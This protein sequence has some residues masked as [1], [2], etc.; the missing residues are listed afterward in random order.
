MTSLTWI[1]VNIVQPY[2]LR[3]SW[4]GTFLAQY[5]ALLVLMVQRSRNCCSLELETFNVTNGVRQGGVLSPVL[6]SVYIDELL[7]RL[8]RLGVGCHFGCRSVG[9]LGYADDSCLLSP[10][11]SAMRILLRECE[12]FAS[13]FEITFNA[14]KLSS[15][16]LVTRLTPVFGPYRLAFSSFLL[17]FSDTVTHL[18]HILHCKL[19]LTSL[20]SLQL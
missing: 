18:G 9:A 14:T 15:F 3:C 12:A 7:L 20:V 1:E 5:T 10:S 19:V 17:S 11:P 6:F 2:R 16:V 4:I 8:S 13:E